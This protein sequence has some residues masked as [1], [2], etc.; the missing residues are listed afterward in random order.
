MIVFTM[1]QLNITYEDKE[2]KE[3]E[4]IKNK[5][6]LNWHDFILEAARQYKGEKK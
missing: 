5:S 6:N 3:L 2:H 4:T 1:K